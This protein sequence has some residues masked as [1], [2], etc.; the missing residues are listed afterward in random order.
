MTKRQR[1]PTTSAKPKSPPTEGPPTEVEKAE[2][3]YAE[4]KKKYDEHAAELQKHGEELEQFRRD[5]IRKVVNV[6]QFNK[7]QLDCF[8]EVFKD[9]PG[10]QDIAKRIMDRAS[11]LEDSSPSALLAGLVRMG[12]L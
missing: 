12:M 1:K 10:I 7:V 9:M 5:Q 8:V 6:V 3:E 2:Q 4:R 11:K